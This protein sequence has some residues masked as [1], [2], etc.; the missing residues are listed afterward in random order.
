MIIKR[1]EGAQRHVASALWT[2]IT[3]W[4]V[5]RLNTLVVQISPL[6]LS[7][8]LILPPFFTPNFLSGLPNQQPVACPTDLLTG[9][10][11]SHTIRRGRRFILSAA[12][13]SLIIIGIHHPAAA[14][15]G[16]L[17]KTLIPQFTRLFATTS[18]PSSS[19]HDVHSH[20]QRIEVGEDAVML[21]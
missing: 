14:G 10:P 11:T 8:P 17:R 6:L 15:R 7:F 3:L 9:R 2:M 1:A 13:P 12:P 19:T 20:S 5:V 18:F 16:A 21:Q 4:P